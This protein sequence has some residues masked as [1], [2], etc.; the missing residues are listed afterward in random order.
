MPKKMAKLTKIA[1]FLPVGSF[2]AMDTEIMKRVAQEAGWFNGLPEHDIAQE[3]D[4]DQSQP[5]QQDSFGELH[6]HGL[7]I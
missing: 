1:R 2:L 6:L 3:R 4:A 5:E 7:N